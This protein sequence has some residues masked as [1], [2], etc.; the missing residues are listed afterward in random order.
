SHLSL[1]DALPI[2][3]G[4]HM[5]KGDRESNISELEANGIA[6]GR[7]SDLEDLV[8]HPQNR[9]IRIKTQHGELELLAPGAFVTG[10]PRSYGPVPAVDEQGQRVRAEFAPAGSTS[11]RKE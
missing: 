9:H 10:Q 3:V 7:L 6:C 8:E 5:L 1:P 2:L 4:E 11:G